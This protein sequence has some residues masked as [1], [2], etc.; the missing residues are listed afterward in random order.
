[1]ADVQLLTSFLTQAAREPFQPGRW[2]CLM[3]LANWVDVATGRDP[4]RDLRGRYRTVMGAARIVEASGGPLAL[5]SR[6]ARRSGL[7]RVSTA[8]PGDVG[9]VWIRGHGSFGAVRGM[10]GRWVV[11]LDR[12]LTSYPFP[13]I[14]VWRL[15]EI[16]VR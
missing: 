16:E 1:M 10:N 3:T 13:H 12:G 6:L 11:K 9:L 14:A 2:D 7:R 8:E 4:A 15:P 5:V